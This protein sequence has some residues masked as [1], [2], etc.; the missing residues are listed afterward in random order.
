M[1]MFFFTLFS[2]SHARRPYCFIYEIAIQ[3]IYII[4]DRRDDRPQMKKKLN[5]PMVLALL[6]AHAKSITGPP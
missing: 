3:L 2:C 1:V 4:P 6:I 5:I